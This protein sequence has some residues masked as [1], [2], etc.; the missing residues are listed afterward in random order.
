LIVNSGEVKVAVNSA[1]GRDIVLD[2][3]G[4]GEIL[5]ELSAIDGAPL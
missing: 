2:V 5:G 4:P 3:L 1:E